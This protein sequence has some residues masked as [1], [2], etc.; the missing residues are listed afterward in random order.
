MREKVI[1]P[2]VVGPYRGDSSGHILVSPGAIGAIRKPLNETRTFI[3]IKLFIVKGVFLE[4]AFIT[5]IY[6]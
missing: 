6:L 5:Y 3:D 4:L 2:D 1:C